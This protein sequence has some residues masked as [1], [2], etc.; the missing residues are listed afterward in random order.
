MY[1]SLACKECLKRLA[2]TLDDSTIRTMQEN[3]DQ[4]GGF[5]TLLGAAILVRHPVNI[6]F[7]ATLDI[8]CETVR[9]TATKMWFCKK[10]IEDSDPVNIDPHSGPVQDG[11]CRNVD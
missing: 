5:S 7:R 11:S 4:A 8:E 9:K 1:A 2:R 3:T 10:I 6:P